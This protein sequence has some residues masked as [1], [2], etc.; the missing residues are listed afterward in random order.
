VHGYL[1]SPPAAAE[2][3]CVHAVSDIYE[4]HRALNHVHEPSD[5]LHVL[6]EPSDALHVL[7]SLALHKVPPTYSSCC[8]EGINDCVELAQNI[9]VLFERVY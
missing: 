7:T 2:L 3:C 4:D 6:T 9:L 1:V 8:L 5:A